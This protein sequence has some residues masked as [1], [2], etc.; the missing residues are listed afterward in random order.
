MPAK[1]DIDSCSVV[2]MYASFIFYF[3]FVFVFY[4]SF[5]IYLFPLEPLRGWIL[6][7]PAPLVFWKATRGLRHPSKSYTHCRHMRS[8]Y[9]WGGEGAQ[10]LSETVPGNTY[11]K[12]LR[13]MPEMTTTTFITIITPGQHL[14][15][16]VCASLMSVR[17]ETTAHSPVWFTPAAL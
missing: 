10:E 17:F 3:Y 1:N 4:F 14:G 8:M 13:K 6:L 16:Q 15:Y 9:A 5:F 11:R 2:K 12:L 7:F